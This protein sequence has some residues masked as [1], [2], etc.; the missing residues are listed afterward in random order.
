MVKTAKMLGD[1]GIRHNCDH[2][3]PN[4]RRIRLGRANQGAFSDFAYPDFLCL[5][6]DGKPRFIIEI[7]DGNGR[8]KDLVGI[9]ACIALCDS[10]IDDGG[11]PVP[12]GKITLVISLN[13][14][15]LEGKSDSGRVSGKSVQLT[16]LKGG[17]QSVFGD[18]IGAI[19][20]VV[21]CEVS[22]LQ[23]LLKTIV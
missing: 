2:V 8:P 7:M 21:F 11:S 1:L 9:V 20:S 17:I 3:P 5:S 22:Q 12:L 16:A 18:G 15:R 4:G 6:S 13:S 23:N 19:D 14:R 10:W